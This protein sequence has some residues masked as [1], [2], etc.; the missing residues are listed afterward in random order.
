MMETPPEG[1]LRN[2]KK[3]KRKSKYKT[4]LERVLIIEASRMI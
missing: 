3:A 2:S 4:K 1:I